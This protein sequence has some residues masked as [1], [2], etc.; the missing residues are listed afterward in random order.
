[1]GKKEE[2]RESTDEFV[3]TVRCLIAEASCTE[4]IDIMCELDDETVKLVVEGLNVRFNG[5]IPW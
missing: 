4:I 3:R 5:E 1:M 2:S